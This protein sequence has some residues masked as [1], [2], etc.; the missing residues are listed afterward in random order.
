MTGLPADAFDTLTQ[1][2]ARICEDP[3]N[4]LLSMPTG[5]NPCER[6]AELDDSGFIAFTVDEDARLIRVYD[7]VWIG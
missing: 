3:Y 5:D 1:T 6:M 2:L 7:L 4:R